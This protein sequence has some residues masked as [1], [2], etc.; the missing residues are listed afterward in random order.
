MK[1]TNID[2][3]QKRSNIRIIRVPEK[4]NWG[5]GAEQILKHNEEL[6]GVEKR[7]KVHMEKAHFSISTSSKIDFTRMSEI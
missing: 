6:S 7:L 3:R 2:D 5:K 4:G 1:L